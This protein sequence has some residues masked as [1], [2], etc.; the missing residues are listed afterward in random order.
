MLCNL[1][2]ALQ[3]HKKSPKRNLGAYIRECVLKNCAPVRPTSRPE[4]AAGAPQPP[5]AQMKV[6]ES[7]ARAWLASLNAAEQGKV[8]QLF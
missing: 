7:T 3:Q 8:L 6:G 4:I 1:E 5:V 2:Y